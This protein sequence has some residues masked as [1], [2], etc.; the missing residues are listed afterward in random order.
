MLDLDSAILAEKNIRFRSG[1]DHSTFLSYWGDWDG[2][3]RPSGQGHRLVATVLMEN[4]S[5]MGRLFRMMLQG[6]S[7]VQADPQ[8]IDEIERL[9]VTSRRF[10]A[11]FDEITDL[12]HQLE[13]RYRG[14]LPFHVQP[15]LARKLGMKL[16]IAT[17]PV[18]SLWE[19]N[20]RLERR[21][22]ELRKK[23]K[24]TLEYYFA[25]NKSLRKGLRANLGALSR[26][27][28]NTDLLLAAAGY[29]DLLRRFV[30]TPRIHQNMITSADPFAIDTTVHN[31]TEI[32]DVAGRHGNP[33]MV[34][35]LQVSMS[36]DP[37][38][39]ISLDRKMRARREE[40]LRGGCAD[41]PSLWL[42]PLFEDVD[43]VR[44][45]PAYL[46]KLWDYAVQSRSLNGTT[47]DR[48]S[49]MIA[50]V[51]IAGSDLSQQIGQTAGLALYKKAKYDIV[52]WLA[53]RGLVGQVR[54][55]M[56]SGEP[57]QRQG[58]YHAPL[59]GRPAFLMTAENERTLGE[60]VQ[61]S[62][63]RSTRYATTPL[64]GIFASGDLRT[65]QSNL[66]ERLRHLPAD[67]LAQVLHHVSEA[68]RFSA[69]ELRRAAEPLTE[70]RLQ[71]TTRGLQEL[72]RLTVGVQDALF[73][74]FMKLAT[75]NFRQILY[76]REE[77]VVGIYAISYFIARTIPPLRDRPTVRPAPG[78]SGTR[79]HK[80]LERIAGTIPFARYGSSLRAIAHHQAQTFVLGVNQ[81]TTGLFRALNFFAQTRSAEGDGEGVLADRILPHLPVYEILQSLRIYQD[82]ELR[83]LTLMERGFPAG[84]SGFTVLREDVDSIRSI[85][86]LFQKELM[87]RHGVNVSEFFEGTRFIPRL[88]PT[89]RPDLAVLMQ[90]DLFNTSVDAI[91]QAGQRAVPDD[92]RKEVE[93]LLR[94]PQE[95]GNW[96]QKAWELL[97]QPVFVRVASFVELA[98]ALHSVAQRIPAAEIVAPP[99]LPRK[100]RDAAT[101]LRG[102]GD[103][104]LQQFLIA[105]VEY[106][107]AIPQGS[108]ELPTNLVRAM[109]EVERIIR[110]EEQALPA[111]DQ[112]MLRFYLLQI[113]RTSGE[114]G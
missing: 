76:G 61:P 32:N 9:P 71:F 58:G 96:R 16:H 104:S 57:M 95:I 114:N 29:R 36:S 91:L 83:W 49:E 67:E 105:A 107:S 17:D 85:V 8:L 86:P 42:V 45:I 18:V 26:Y 50:E 87:R 75:E 102:P 5:R 66:A 37:E 3:N 79:G 88:L 94:I 101:V 2:S 55:K 93:R 44:R 41:M 39:L 34:L 89:L 80:I 47:E 72:E 73:D 13:K 21:M 69:G 92:W 59:S 82:V 65:F 77:D 38:A 106:L 84:N 53:E 27:S 113:A 78:S 10:R 14:V 30:I 68:Q 63:K 74:E 51:F 64:M 1:A 24:R 46:G 4:V 109:K 56:G 70:T 15:G 52:R 31:I 90:P 54:I 97:E 12:T 43:L 35:A 11:L 60:C 99:A 100:L 25:L 20:D 108:I 19:H 110:I 62:A 6:A 103:D 98:T 33:G 48:F 28:K 112:D 40:S 7:G 22:L 81:L 111:R 23:R